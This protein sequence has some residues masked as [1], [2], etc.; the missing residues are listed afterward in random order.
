MLTLND[1]TDVVSIGNEAERTKY[2]SLWYRTVD[3]I[4]IRS[5]A[6]KDN[7]LGAAS[8]IGAKPIESDVLYAESIFKKFSRTWWS[9]VSNTALRSNKTSNERSL[10]SMAWTMSLCTESTA[11]SVEWNCRYADCLGGNKLNWVAWDMNCWLASFSYAAIKV[12]QRGWSVCGWLGL[13]AFASI[14]GKRGPK[15]KIGVDHLG[16]DYQVTLY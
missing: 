12:E 4:G 14:S 1:V 11:V 5:R 2:G 6:T 7:Q 9:T 13:S 10:L 8:K 3:C 15:S 16:A